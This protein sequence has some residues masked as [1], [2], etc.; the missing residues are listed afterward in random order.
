MRRLRGCLRPLTRAFNRD[1]RR[2]GVVFRI[3]MNPVALTGR[4][5]AIKRA[6]NEHLLLP[7]PPLIRLQGRERETG[8]RRAYYAKRSSR[9]GH[10]YE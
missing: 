6:L 7:L 8:A 9:G 2:P 10:V 4:P 5:P 3:S 1:L